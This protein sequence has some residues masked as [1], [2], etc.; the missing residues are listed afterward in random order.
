[1]E[2]K[3][4]ALYAAVLTGS[5]E[6]VRLSLSTGIHLDMEL[7]CNAY[8]SPL[9]SAILRGYPEIVKYL[10]K[11]G[12]HVNKQSVKWKSPLHT[13]IKYNTA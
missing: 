7:A 8:Y 11:R 9:I 4:F 2:D 5:T 13:C 3:V 1:M 10:I 6:M 12:A